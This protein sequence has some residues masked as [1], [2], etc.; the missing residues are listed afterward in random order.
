MMVVSPPL[1]LALP[2]VVLSR[3]WRIPYVFHVADLQPD[4]AV[5]LGMLM[6]GR[7]TQFLYA[8]EKLA[9]RNAA[10]ISTLTEGMRRRIIA[11]G[12]AANNVKLF[13]DWAA[14]EFF[15]IPLADAGVSFRTDH[16][17][18]SHF[19]VLHAGNMGVKQGLDVV[20]GAAELS[21]G[22]TELIYLLV[23]DGAARPALEAYAAAAA[24]PN[25]R[26]MPLQ[27]HPKFID[28]LAAVD[29]CLITQQRSV[30][31]VVFPS[32]TLTLMAAARPLIASVN[33]RS[34]VARVV[35]EAGA[36]VVV[37]PENPQALGRAV[38]QLR[39]E[40]EERRAMGRRAREYSR[41]KWEREQILAE[42]AAGLAAVAAS[43][44]D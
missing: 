17:L 3:L 2:A 8:I 4:A 36:G 20:L 32:K 16:G 29:V 5:D 44:S 18:D 6:Q 7:L 22:D 12:I 15:G 30:A 33:S 26:F 39:N 11:K 31:D 25:V 35:T 28:L 41:T 43:S 24:L 14:P 19:L 42:T 37:E 38:E 21:R 13:S 10:L 1:G 27:P 40:P 34:E 9:Y 23:G